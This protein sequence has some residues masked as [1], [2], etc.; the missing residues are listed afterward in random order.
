M[1]EL[2]KKEIEY[3]SG[4]G[5]VNDV[6]RVAPPK[7]NTGAIHSAQNKSTLTPFIATQHMMCG[8]NIHGQHVCYPPW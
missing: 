5:T 4:G 8:P 1:R 2:N 7:Q 3:V 6:I